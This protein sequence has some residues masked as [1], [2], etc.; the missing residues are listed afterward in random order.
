VE[1]EGSGKRAEETIRGYSMALVFSTTAVVDG[2]CMQY[3]FFDSRAAEV[4]H[5]V[6][7]FVSFFVLILAIFIFCYWRILVVIR[8]QASVMTSYGSSTPSTSQL[9]SH[10]IQS[11]V[12]KTMI[13]V[14]T[15]FIVCWLPT[16]FYYLVLSQYAL[17][18]SS[19]YPTILLASL[20]VC[21]NP[22]IYAMKFEPVKRILLNP[23]SARNPTVHWEYAVSAS[24]NRA[25][26]AHR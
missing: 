25:V 19:Y 21:A 16:S 9:Q 2:I 26:A 6:W 18:V 14:S 8:R 11:N 7:N 13:I 5:G 1:N 12:I 22:F 20:Y 24:A 4:A 23:I 17:P 3:A 10:E 15:F